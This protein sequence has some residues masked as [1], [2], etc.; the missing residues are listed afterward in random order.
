MNLMKVEAFED[1]LAVSHSTV[2][3]K[4][5]N[6]SLKTCSFDFRLRLPEKNIKMPILQNRKQ[7]NLFFNIIQALI[8]KI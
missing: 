7:R 1:D 3:K 5:S 8:N 6:R 4:A 2:T